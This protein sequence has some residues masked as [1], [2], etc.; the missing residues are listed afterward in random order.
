MNNLHDNNKN[1]KSF[2]IFSFYLVHN[3]VAKIYVKATSFCTR[4]KCEHD[5]EEKS[6][7]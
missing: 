4:P 5:H 2:E 3:V 7:M 1:Y 6:Q